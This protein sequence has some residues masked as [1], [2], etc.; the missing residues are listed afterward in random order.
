MLI[1]NSNHNLKSL[2]LT[3]AMLLSINPSRTCWEVV[4]KTIVVKILICQNI[5]PSSPQG[6]LVNCEVAYRQRQLC[7]FELTQP[8]P[9]ALMDY[10]RI[11]TI[12][13]T[14]GTKVMQ[15]SIVTVLNLLN[16]KSHCNTQISSIFSLSWKRT[17]DLN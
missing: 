11:I 8:C 2:S 1:A 16:C 3:S 4:F 12:C 5:F 10:T 6:K 13:P 17:V 7:C 9:Y 14:T 15:I